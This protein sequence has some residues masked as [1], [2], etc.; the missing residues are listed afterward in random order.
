LTVCLLCNARDKLTCHIAQVT[1]APKEVQKARAA[2]A[3]AA[4]AARRKEDA[5]KAAGKTRMKGKNRPTARHRKRQ[6]NIIEV[7][8][9]PTAR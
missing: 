1:K 9:T 3:Q 5:A 2:E 7:R 4:N 6:D 8:P